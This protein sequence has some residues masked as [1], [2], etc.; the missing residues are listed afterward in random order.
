LGDERWPDHA[1]GHA[2]EVTLKRRVHATG[3]RLLPNFAYRFFAGWPLCEP[4]ST[5]KIAG[6]LPLWLDGRIGGIDHG[7]ADVVSSRKMPDPRI[8]QRG[9]VHS[10]T[11]GEGSPAA[12]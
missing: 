8:L 11:G 2:A 9:P 3:A 7:L 12:R 4:H 10:Q 6:M 1:P 5:A